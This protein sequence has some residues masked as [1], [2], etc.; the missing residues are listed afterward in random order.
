MDS[1]FCG[2]RSRQIRQR[3]GAEHAEGVAE[4]GEARSTESR[5]SYVQLQNEAVQ[6]GTGVKYIWNVSILPP[7]IPLRLH[8]ILCY[9]LQA[10]GNILLAISYLPTAQRLTINVMK[11]RDVKFTPPVSCLNDFSKRRT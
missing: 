7:S 9:M 6:F 2:V 4:G 5:D 8:D 1:R 11:V 10:L 3:Y